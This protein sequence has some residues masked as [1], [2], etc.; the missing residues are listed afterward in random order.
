MK[1]KNGNKVLKRT[2]EKN[3]WVTGKRVIQH[4]CG[5]FVFSPLRLVFTTNRVFTMSNAFWTVM[6]T[7]GSETARRFGRTY[8]L[9][10]SGLGS[11]RTRRRYN[12]EVH[13]ENLK[14]NRVIAVG[15]IKWQEAVQTVLI[16]HSG[17]RRF[18]KIWAHQS[19][20]CLSNH[21]RSEYDRHAVCI[22]YTY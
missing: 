3:G 10:S 15:S 9:P 16:C 4:F 17:A 22:V 7:G 18:H 2:K 13:R 5:F 11:L 6:L 20:P 8:S 12:P 21:T 19:Q 14:S 1:Q